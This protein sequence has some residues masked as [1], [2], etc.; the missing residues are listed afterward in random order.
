MYLASGLC[1]ASEACLRLMLQQR[2]VRGSG[3]EDGGGWLR[4]TSRVSE[5]YPP[6]SSSSCRA[7]RTSR[8]QLMVDAICVV[9]GPAHD[10]KE[11]GECASLQCN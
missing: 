2:F 3:T 4:C 7:Q 5:P 6:A 8:H 11:P 10:V 1:P 9:V